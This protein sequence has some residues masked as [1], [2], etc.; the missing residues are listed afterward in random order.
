MG[1]GPEIGILAK[2]EDFGRRVALAI[3]TERTGTVYNGVRAVGTV[4][5]DASV[6]DDRAVDGELTSTGGLA[7]TLRIGCGLLAEV[8]T[9]VD[10]TRN[11]Q[12]SINASD[13]ASNIEVTVNEDD[14]LG[15]LINRVVGTVG[16]S[17]IVRNGEGITRIT[18]I[19]I[20]ICA[21]SVEIGINIRA[22]FSPVA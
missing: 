2:V 3:C 19:F 5:G 21:R 18:S 14:V 16:V 22:I 9:S 13:V 20:D 12:P 15:E 17:D 8:T 1:I 6:R 10:F 4:Q 11:D 7:Q